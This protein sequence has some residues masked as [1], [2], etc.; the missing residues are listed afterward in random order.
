VYRDF[1]NATFGVIDQFNKLRAVD[2]GG[3]SLAHNQ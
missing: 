1:F 3:T 2:H